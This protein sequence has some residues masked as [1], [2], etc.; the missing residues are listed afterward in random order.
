MA[1]LIPTAANIP[2]LWLAAYDLFPVKAM[3]EKEI[4]LNESVEKNYV[5]FFEHDFYNECATVTKN[6]KGFLAKE[7]F[8]WEKFI[9]GKL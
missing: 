3:E 9:S 6:I 5:L 8:S 2:L 4:F 1:D 7:I